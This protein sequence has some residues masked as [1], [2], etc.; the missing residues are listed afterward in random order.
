[1]ATMTE[2]K[3]KKLDYVIL[4]VHDTEKS[5]PFYRDLLGM[6]VKEAHPG[7]VELESEGLT[8][9]LHG[10]DSLP[11]DRKE[12]TTIVFGVKDI[13]A[14]VEALKTKGVHFEKDLHEVCGDDSHVGLSADF[15]DTDGNSLSI[16]EYVKR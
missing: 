10:S 9:A 8:I 2:V 3:L 11:A 7:W 1:M 12:L 4:Y 15:R 6:T 16:F 13:N 5:L 14:A